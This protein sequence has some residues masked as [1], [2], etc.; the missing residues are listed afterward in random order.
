MVTVGSVNYS[1]KASNVGH[2]HKAMISGAANHW[3][4]YFLAWTFQIP[5]Q[6]TDFVFRDP[7][8]P[9]PGSVPFQETPF[10]IQS[11]TTQ[12]QGFF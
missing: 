12:F 10:D 5:E 4:H 6:V 7:Q 2:M 3:A 9:F 11:R 1:T 8:C